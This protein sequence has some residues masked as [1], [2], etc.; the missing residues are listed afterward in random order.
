MLRLDTR[1]GN[2]RALEN[3]CVLHPRAEAV[4]NV[5]YAHRYRSSRDD[6]LHFLF[7]GFY[8][9]SFHFLFYAW[10]VDFDIVL[11]FELLKLRVALEHNILLFLEFI[12][13]EEFDREIERLKFS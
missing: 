13:F 4:H 2:R 6:S 10:Y 1:G 3:P 9:V 8:T 7:F 12:F 5:A 11:S